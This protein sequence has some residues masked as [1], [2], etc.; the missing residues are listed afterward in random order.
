[1]VSRFCYG[2]TND[3]AILISACALHNSPCHPISSGVFFFILQYFL[4]VFLQNCL[5]FSLN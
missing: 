3:I 5:L 1:M 2:N 4:F